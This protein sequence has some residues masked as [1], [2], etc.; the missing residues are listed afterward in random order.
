MEEQR[1]GMLSPFVKSSSKKESSL[2]LYEE[3][4]LLVGMPQKP[5]QLGTS[6]LGETSLRPLQRSALRREQ[7][8]IIS[9]LG[10][11]LVFLEGGMDASTSALLSH[12]QLNVSR[13]RG[14]RTDKAPSLTALD[15]EFSRVFHPSTAAAEA[16]ALR[17]CHHFLQVGCV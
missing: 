7:A 16:E 6:Q 11:N 2:G 5:S 10:N 17:P 14:R 1:V 15:R 9:P 4:P 12:S 8:G 3:D 13:R